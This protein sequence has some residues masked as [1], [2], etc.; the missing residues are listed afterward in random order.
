MRNE[1]NEYYPVPQDY[2]DMT[3]WDELAALASVAYNQLDENQKKDWIIYAN[4]YGQAG[5]LDF[6]GKKYHLPTPTCV[7]D[8]YIFWAPDSL[9]ASNYIVSDDELGDIPKLFNNYHEIGEIKDIYFRENGLKVFLCQNPKPLLNEFFKK[10][11][12][13]HKAIYGY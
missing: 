12:K 13:E 11:I 2:M 4:D 3:G 9:S 8:S 7:H 1:D 10:R 6:Y 5:A